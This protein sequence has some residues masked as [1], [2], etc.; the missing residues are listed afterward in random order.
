MR[1][2][3]RGILP[4]HS[5]VKC[6]RGECVCNA[7][8]LPALNRS[9]HS[10]GHKPPSRAMHAAAM[11]VHHGRTQTQLRQDI[12]LQ[13][14]TARHCLQGARKR[15]SAL[16]R[17][18]CM[19]YPL[20]GSTGIRPYDRHTRHYMHPYGQGL[21]RPTGAKP[22]RPSPQQVT[23]AHRGATHDPPRKSPKTPAHHTKTAAAPAPVYAKAPHLL[24]T[25]HCRPGLFCSAITTIPQLPCTPS[26]AA[27]P[28]PQRS[29]P[30]PP[31]FSPPPC[32]SVASCPP[33][34]L[35]PQA[36]AAP[37]CSNPP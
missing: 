9:C 32:P 20:A 15:F 29:V 12:V 19:E 31:P 13:A 26:P 2:Y 17:P 25:P 4:R 5:R 23:F 28:P 7:S 8:A 27:T 37:A 3:A 24:C 14:I 22:H 36:T 6:H 1:C 33:V 10:V 35:P 34:H 18:L 16:L 11:A 30:W 21:P